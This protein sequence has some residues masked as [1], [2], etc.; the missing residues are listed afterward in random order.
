MSN[1]KSKISLKLPSNTITINYSLKEKLS[2]THMQLYNS[3]KPTKHFPNINNWATPIHSDAAYNLGATTPNLMLLP[4][5]NNKSVSNNKSS[6]IKSNTNC[7]MKKQS[8][9]DL[10]YKKSQSS[11]FP[12]INS[13]T[14]EKNSTLRNARYSQGGKRNLARSSSKL[15]II[16]DIVALK[17][18]YIT[19]IEQLKLREAN[20]LSSIQELEH[21]IKKIQ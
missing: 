18:S 19:L 11:N 16:N 5:S 20:I 15:S 21:K 14:E 12:N 10:I 17:Y 13:E 8:F 4:N 7:E 6:E 9:N 2:P 3:R 1:N